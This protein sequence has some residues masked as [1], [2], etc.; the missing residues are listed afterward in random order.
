MVEQSLDWISTRPVVY[1]IT[2]RRLS[3]DTRLRSRSFCPVSVALCFEHGSV[4]SRSGFKAQPMRALAG[5]LVHWCLNLIGCQTRAV[6]SDSDSM[7]IS[8]ESDQPKRAKVFFNKLSFLKS[9]RY[10]RILFCRKFVLRLEVKSV[11]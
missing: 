4:C 10:N 5:G 3:N 2:A 1:W 6:D 9:K 8:I 7:R 11:L